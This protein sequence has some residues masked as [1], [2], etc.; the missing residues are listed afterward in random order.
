M[1]KICER[2]IELSIIGAAFFLPLS[3]GAVNTLLGMAI[4]FWLLKKC[5]K[6]DLTL[7]Y[8]R[9]NLPLFLFFI[10]ACLSIFNSI[11]PGTSLKGLIKVLKYLGIYFMMIEGVNDLRTAKR[12]TA[13]LLIGASIACIDGVIQYITGRDALRSNPLIINIG[14]KRMTAAYKH[15]NDFGIYLVTVVPVIWTLALYEFKKLLK[16]L[17]LAAAILI[18]VCV[19]LTFS[20][21]AVLAFYGAIALMAVVKKDKWVMLALAVSLAAMPFL[22]PNGVKEWGKTTKS[23]IEFFCNA[24]RIAF[25]RSAVHM[26]KDHPVIGVG[27]NT[28]MK[29]YPKYKVRDVT[30]ITA[31]Q[32]YAHNNYLQMA[33]E[34]GLTGLGIFLWILAAFFLEIKGI[35]G[36]D[37]DKEGYIRNAALGLGCGI[38]AFC[39]NG[40][41]ESSFYFSKLVVVFWFI[42]GLA[43]SLRR[44]K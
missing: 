36:N 28:F 9:L 7:R 15:C 18:T 1:A 23:P 42:A 31:E 22:I 35:I 17:V 11:E 19:V 12:I 10:I 24:D 32:C 4:V 16:G 8:T 41:T 5:L 30:V 14:L 44:I 37:R 40:L 6:K 34:M 43:V 20:R 27:I 3:S 26:I 21:G 25:Y 2:V 29:A 39:L 13:A 38:F 33:G